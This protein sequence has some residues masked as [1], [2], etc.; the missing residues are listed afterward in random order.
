MGQL[1]VEKGRVVCDVLPAPQDRLAQR[2][3]VTHP[4]RGT[5]WSKPVSQTQ[6][7][8]HEMPP[9]PSMPWSRC[10]WRSSSTTSYPPLASEKQKNEKERE[11]PDVCRCR[12][13]GLAW[14]GGLGQGGPGHE[15]RAA[16]TRCPRQEPPLFTESDRRAFKIDR[17]LSED[18]LAGHMAER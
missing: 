6:D 5:L 11:K 4:A 3:V 14:S 2:G 7:A 9:P 13:P 16:L 17:V 18:V 15:S 12:C 8:P 10:T 1:R